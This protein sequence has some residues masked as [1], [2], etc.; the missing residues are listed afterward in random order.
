M[1]KLYFYNFNLLNFYL[2]DKKIVNI[3]NKVFI[4]NIGQI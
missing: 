3:K 2:F 1:F 4:L